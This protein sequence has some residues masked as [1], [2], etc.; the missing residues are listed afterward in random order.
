MALHNNNEPYMQPSQRGEKK[1]VGAHQVFDV[2]LREAL[3]VDRLLR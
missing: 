2:I 3:P 1:Y